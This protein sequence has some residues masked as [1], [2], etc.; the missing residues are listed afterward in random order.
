VKKAIL[1]EDIFNHG[2]ALD[3]FLLHRAVNSEKGLNMKYVIGALAAILTASQA[4]A[5]T[6]SVSSLL[7]VASQIVGK[8]TNSDPCPEP[9]TW[10]LMLVGFTLL[11]VVTRIRRKATA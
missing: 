2:S 4:G 5:A 6:L 9:A 3:H 10:A 7:P 11:A 8:V 1:G